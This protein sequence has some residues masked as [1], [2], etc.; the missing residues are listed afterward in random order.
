MNTIGRSTNSLDRSEDLKEQ[1][2]GVEKNAHFVKKAYT[3]IRAAFLATLTVVGM[4]G[5]YDMKFKKEHPII[6]KEGEHF[7]QMLHSGQEMEGELHPR[8]IEHQQK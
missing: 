8:G 4:Q 7:A 6:A 3:V 1:N 5:Y 2:D